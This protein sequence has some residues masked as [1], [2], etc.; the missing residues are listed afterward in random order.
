MINSLRNPEKFINSKNV[1]ILKELLGLLRIIK[2]PA[3]Q[4]LGWKD[5][6]KEKADQSF[7]TNFI[8]VI[9]LRKFR[10]LVGRGFFNQ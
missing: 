1:K 2:R 10:E 5:L 7:E 8:K 9:N 6:R 3:D 4:W